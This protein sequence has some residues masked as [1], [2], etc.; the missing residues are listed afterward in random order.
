MAIGATVQPDAQASVIEAHDIVVLV[1]RAKQ[2]LVSRLRVSGVPVVHDIVD[3]WPQPAGNQWDRT[4]CLSWLDAK[5]R[6]IRPVAVIAATKAMRQDLQAM[7]VPALDIPHHARPGVGRT[8]IRPIKVVGYE[9]GLQHL[10]SWRDWLDA[11]CKRRGL[12]F[13][14][15][16]A[17]L[18]EL[19]IVVALREHLGY[20]PRLWKSNVKL[21][22]AQGSGTPIICSR[23]AGYL[24][25]ESGAER[26]ADTHKEVSAA[27]DELAPEDVRRV[28]SLTLYRRAPC[29]ESIAADYWRFLRSLC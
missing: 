4:T 10:G 16:P 25:T 14:V 28:A 15:N 19:D 26:W 22:N 1:K 8:D 17:S 23:E 9:G 20:A 13:V 27:L 2:P 5:V 29:L 12:K 6:E 3:A 18:S 7:G 24:E 11:E 21:A